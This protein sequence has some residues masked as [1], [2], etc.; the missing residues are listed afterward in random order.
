ML[1]TWCFSIL[2]L[3]HCILK[4]HYLLKDFLAVRII[5]NDIN[6]LGDDIDVLGNKF[7]SFQGD[8]IK[9]SLEKLKN[10][11]VILAF[12]G[13][14]IFKD[15]TTGLTQLLKSLLEHAR[16]M[17]K[18]VI[19]LSH[20]RRCNTCSTRISKIIENLLGFSE[21]SKCAFVINPFSKD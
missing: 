10:S 5:H 1:L 6:F 21:D 9:G 8:L 19:S 20:W 15:D 13:D 18:L 17:V 14:D 4:S 11:K 16:N 3:Y 7:L 2:V 12:C